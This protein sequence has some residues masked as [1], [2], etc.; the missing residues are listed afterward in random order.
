MTEVPTRGR[1]EVIRSL[2]RLALAAL[3]VLSF[4][5]PS[6]ARMASIQTT[7][8]LPDHSEQSIETALAGA[9]ETVVHRAVALGFSSAAI[10]QTLV[11]EDVVSVQILA[12]DTTLEPEDE[13][14]EEPG[15][16]GGGSTT[17]DRPEQGDL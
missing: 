17:I 6:P 8:H 10:T 3:L 16:G 15:P 9:V 14:A 5:A 2:G 7:A 11:R 12:T 1:S 13:D 4:A